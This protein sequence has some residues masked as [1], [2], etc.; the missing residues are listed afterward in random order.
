MDDLQRFSVH[1]LIVA[2]SGSDADKLAEEIAI[3]QTAEMPPETIPEPLR[4]SFT[5][6][7]V[8]CKEAGN[9]QYEAV[10]SYPLAVAGNE[11]TQC[12]NMIFGNISM[13][14]GIRLSGIGWHALRHLFPGPY[15]GI[16]G[17][18]E[19][20]HI[21]NRPLSCSALKPV[22][23]N[24]AQ[25]ANRCYQMAKGGI[26]IIKDDH[27][28]VNQ[29]SAPF[30]DR[31]ETCMAAVEKAADETGKR[32]AYFPNIT[33]DCFDTWRRYEIAQSLGASGVLISPQLTGMSAIKSLRDSEPV[34]PV[35][36][37]P[38]FSGSF[39]MDKDHGF[40][41]EL[42]YGFLWRAL[43]ADT[44]IYPNSGGRFSFTDDEC[45]KI[46][47]ALRDESSPFKKA[48]PTPGG[49]IQRETIGKWIDRYGMDTIFLI[50]GS[51]YQHKHGL[52]TAVREFQD[53][54]ENHA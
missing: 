46:N 5:G 8:I 10:I 39:V 37:H 12:L 13:K 15:Y 38:T 34:L 7:V 25:L 19:K 33:G 32:A 49:G 6:K 28:L 11:L 22:G 4:H 40:T 29:T 45:R 1:Y 17:I 41:P 26:D 31:V 35:M 24:S 53:E 23:L 27:G 30:Y 47:G 20:L 44:V 42:Y 9:H 43:G 48:F 36:A 14:P 54:I 18:R 52:E 2:R 50:G 51:L 3:E 16:E 21:Y